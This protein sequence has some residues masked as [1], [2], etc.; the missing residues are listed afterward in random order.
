MTTE[1]VA[2]VLGLGKVN[3]G[4]G[5]GGGG[6][7]GGLRRTLVPERVEVDHFVS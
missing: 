2:R 5:G 1:N 7:D 4:G 6:D 3:G